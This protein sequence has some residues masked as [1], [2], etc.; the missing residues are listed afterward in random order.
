MRSGKFHPHI[1]VT[2]NPQIQNFA[3]RTAAIR[4]VRDAE[5]RIFA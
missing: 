3:N 1:S 4:I 2:N 5:R